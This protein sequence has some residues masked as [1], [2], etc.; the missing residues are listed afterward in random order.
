MSPYLFTSPVRKMN[1]N[2]NIHIVPFTNVIRIKN[3]NCPPKNNISETDIH[4][5]IQR[6]KKYEFSKQIKIPLEDY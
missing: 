4:T 5:F 3:S 1:E 2:D 6:I